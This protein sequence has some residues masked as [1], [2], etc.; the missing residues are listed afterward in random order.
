MLV[1][2]KVTGGA[3]FRFQNYLTADADMEYFLLDGRENPGI[4]KQK[5]T[6]AHAD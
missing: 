5:S 3:I 4:W 6:T 2:A 1:Q